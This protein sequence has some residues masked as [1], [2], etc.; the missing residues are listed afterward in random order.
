[1]PFG[2]A[3]VLVSGLVNR[4]RVIRIGLLRSGFAGEAIVFEPVELL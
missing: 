2:I 3:M 1:M 4:P